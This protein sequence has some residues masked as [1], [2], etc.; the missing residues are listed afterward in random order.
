VTRGINVQAN[1]ALF[2]PQANTDIWFE[3][4][5]KAADINTGP[6]FA[7]GLAEIDTTVIGSSAISTANHVMFG[8][9][10]DDGILLG[11]AEKATAAVADNS[12]HTLVEDTWVRL[13]LKISGVDKVEWYVNGVKD[14]TTVATANVPIV[15]LV[16]T[17]VCQS[18]GTT[19]SIVHIDW[20]EFYQSK[21]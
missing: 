21:R 1:A 18:D 14:P 16:P 13:G 9:V 4:R 11:N 15:V 2:K 10:T 12:V 19:D 20:W 3:A 17:L 5:I 8:S 6:E 7:L